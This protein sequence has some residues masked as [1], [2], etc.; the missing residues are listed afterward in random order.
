MSEQENNNLRSVSISTKQNMPISMGS[1]EYIAGIDPKETWA[2]VSKDDMDVEEFEKLR[3]KH[4]EI[5]KEKESTKE[6]QDSLK[7]MMQESLK[8]YQGIMSG[9]GEVVKPY[10]SG[11]TFNFIL[12]MP[13]TGGTTL[14]QALS[15]VYGWPWENLLLSMTHNFM[16]NGGYILSNPTA[17]FDMGWRLPWNFNNIVF[18]LSQ[19]L[20]YINNEAP[21]SEHIFIKSTA[22]SYAVKLLNFLFFG[23]A[24]NYFVTVRHPGA[25]TMTSGKEEITRE[26]HM[27]T[28]AMWANLYSSII[29]D[30]RPLGRMRIVEYGQGLTDVINHAFESK[31]MGE[32]IEDSAF[33]ELEDYDKEFYESDTVKR[34]FEYVKMSWGLFDLEFPEIGEC[35]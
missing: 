4:M 6:F 26:D 5:I 28:M 34:M 9:N 21:D 18:E 13:R 8:L 31:K 25:I 30:C 14:Y 16:P 17:E 15:D 32:R 22:L 23:D 7:D 2:P 1:F 24:A 11:R 20:V 35:I 19:F 10:T 12:G 3:A 29:R 33:F 27:E